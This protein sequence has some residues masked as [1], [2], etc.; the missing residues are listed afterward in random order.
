[1]FNINKNIAVI[2]FANTSSE[3]VKQKNIV[4]SG[5]L[6]EHLNNQIVSEVEKSGLD[7][8][9]ISN[10]EQQGNNFAERFTNAIETVFSKG[11]QHVITIGN[12]SPNLNSKHLKTAVENIL[13]N[14]ATIGPSMD[15]GAYLISI[16]KNWFDK[17]EFEEIP[18]QTKYVYTSLRKYFSTRKIH[19]NQLEYLKDIDS[20]VDL[21]YFLSKFKCIDIVFRQLVLNALF[22]NTQPIFSIVSTYQNYFFSNHHNKGSP[23]LML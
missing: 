4:Q 15:G 13:N 5:I 2:F 19:T 14:T 9:H 7:L 1:M 22:L 12:D 6:F 20:T 3:E 23:Q 21:H 16:S 10:K 17:K 11:Y 18:W 8:I